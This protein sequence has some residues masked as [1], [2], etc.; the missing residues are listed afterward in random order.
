LADLRK[1]LELTEHLEDMTLKHVALINIQKRIKLVC[2]EKYGI[3]VESAEGKGT[4]VSILLP[5]RF[6]KSP[7][8]KQS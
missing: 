1:R 7:S 5:K 8:F 6:P 3:T 4:K 2:G